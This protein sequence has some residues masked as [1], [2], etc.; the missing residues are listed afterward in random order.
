MYY[1][2]VARKFFTCFLSIF[3]FL[4]IGFT[5]VKTSQ[6]PP[7]ERPWYQR[8]Q[9]YSMVAL[10]PD[11]VEN[12]HITVNGLWNGYFGGFTSPFAFGRVQESQ[13][14]GKNY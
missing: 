5:K 13:A 9:V 12:F 3:L 14:S 11:D 10:G 2:H 1:L 8:V 7:S 4:N 6:E